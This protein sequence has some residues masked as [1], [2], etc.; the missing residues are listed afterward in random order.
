MENS[1]I[2]SGIEPVNTE[3][4]IPLILAI[5]AFV[6]G[7][8]SFVFAWS[9]KSALNRHKDNILREVSEAVEASKQAAADARNA[10][11]G[12]EGIAALSTDF[13]ELKAMVRS[14]Y[15][16]ISVSQKQIVENAKSL[17]ARLARLEGNAPQTPVAATP[18]RGDAPAAPGAPTNNGKYK[19]QKGDYPGKIAKKLGVTTKEL[20][21]ANPGLDPKRLQI[22]QELNVPAK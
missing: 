7:G 5:A 11:T 19:V 15:D 18:N 3:S 13:E 17:N 8:L 1:S 21:D 14:G 9:T 16:K 12:G 4:K 20:L 22:G 6:L 2:D 10:G